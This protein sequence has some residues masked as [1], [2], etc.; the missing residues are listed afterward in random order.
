MRCSLALSD[1]FRLSKLG[2]TKPFVYQI[3]CVICTGTPV[4]GLTIR[5]L[6]IETNAVFS[7]Y[8][9]QHL[10]IILLGGVYELVYVMIVERSAT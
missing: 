3:Y 10:L 6:K 7:I 5:Y 2:V 8:I 4:T 9:L 1:E